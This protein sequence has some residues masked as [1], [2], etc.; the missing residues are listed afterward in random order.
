[1]LLS[2]KCDDPEEFPLQQEKWSSQGNPALS[3]HFVGIFQI[4]KKKLKETNKST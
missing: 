4:Y 3:F 2:E 1:V